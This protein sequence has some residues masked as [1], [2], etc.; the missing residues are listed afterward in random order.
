MGF[1]PFINL[2]SLDRGFVL[3]GFGLRGLGAVMGN[4]LVHLGGCLSIYMMIPS[5]SMT[6]MRRKLL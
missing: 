2:L 4:K 1:D 3:M 6:C 5:K